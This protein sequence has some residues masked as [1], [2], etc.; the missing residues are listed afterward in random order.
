[1]GLGKPPK[2]G[3][4]ETL[5]GPKC[6]GATDHVR[7]RKVKSIWEKG[8]LIGAGQ[9]EKIA[10]ALKRADETV[11]GKSSKKKR[12][13]SHRQASGESFAQCRSRKQ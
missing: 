3:G 5:D 13:G 4:S 2:G 7:P 12:T 10:S 8:K 11:L 1:M 9:K 6:I